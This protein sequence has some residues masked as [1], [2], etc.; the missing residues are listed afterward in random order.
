MAKPRGNN[1][2][3]AECIIDREQDIGFWAITVTYFA[4]LT[5]SV[6]AEDF[7][8]ILSVPSQKL[9]YESSLLF[10]SVSM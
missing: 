9:H 3:G 7:P 2:S 4:G 5:V 1:C 10:E 8:R 6:C